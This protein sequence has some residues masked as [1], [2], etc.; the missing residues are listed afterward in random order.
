MTLQEAIDRLTKMREKYG[1][2]ELYFDCPNCKQAYTPNVVVP[3]V[4]AYG[5]LEKKR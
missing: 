2:V 4:T 1:D 5:D 3:S